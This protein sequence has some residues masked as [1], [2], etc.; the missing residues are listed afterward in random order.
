MTVEGAA[1]G[2]A[3]GTQGATVDVFFVCEEVELEVETAVKRTWAMRTG[4]VMDS[5]VGRRG[6]VARTAVTSGEGS[7]RSGESAE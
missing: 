7:R 5:V 6:W 2:E 3:F 4:V 1:I